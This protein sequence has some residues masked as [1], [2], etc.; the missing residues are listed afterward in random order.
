[1]LV[2]LYI[3]NFGLIDTLEVEMVS[4]LN[5]LTGET[6][7]GKSIIVEALKVSLGGKCQADMIRTGRE[8]ALVQ[9]VFE[10][11]KSTA[12]FYKLTAN[13]LEP[14]EQEGDLLIMSRELNRQGRNTCR[15]NGR[16]VNLSAFREVSALLV[17]MHGQHDQQALL[18]TEKQLG[19]LDRYGGP[20]LA[21]LVVETQTAY[22]NWQAAIRRQEEIISGS[23]ERQ[24]RIDMLEYQIKE[25]NAAGLAGEDETELYQKRNKLANAERIGQLAAS[26][27]QKIFHGPD[28]CPA[29]IDL[30]GRSKNELEELCRY[31]PD[32]QNCLENIHSALCLVEDA[33]RDLAACRESVEIDPEELG[34][35]EER[36]ALIEKL[37]RKYAATLAGVLE[38]CEQISFEL[39]KLQ[40]LENQS[41]DIEQQVMDNEEKYLKSAGKT[42]RL[43]LETAAKLEKAVQNEL[44]EMEMLQVDFAVELTTG[45]PTPAGTDS[46]QFLF[47]P[48]PGEPLKPLAK[49][50]SGGELSRVMLALRSVLAVADE[51]QTLVFDEID[52]GIGGR[53]IHAIAE[54]L[55]ELGR[56]RQVIC[57]THAAAV[58]ACASNHY[59]VAKSTDGQRTVTTLKHLGGEERVRELS[60]MVGGIED[61]KLLTGYVRKMLK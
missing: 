7:A 46:L 60:R 44:R 5:V 57:I 56:Q 19:L 35:V 10:V 6:G 18:S 54:R 42:S 37:K 55:E 61:S 51:T 59:L 47:S 43:R 16:V 32:S 23:R 14:G 50:A 3:Q 31:L 2:S 22:R 17:E 1:M 38:Y 58:A 40:T 11:G 4:G 24:Q 25:I 27:L 26:V 8:R 39:E 49:I 13:G 30:L 28:H 53:T 12:V 36:L 34:R 52:V 9:S 15:I 20:D 48:N 45:E 29:A 33:A 21:A 41:V